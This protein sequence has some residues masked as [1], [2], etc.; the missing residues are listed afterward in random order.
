M[1][2][3]FVQYAEKYFKILHLLRV[4]GYANVESLYRKGF[5]RVLVFDQQKVKLLQSKLNQR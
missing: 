5:M 2:N 1:T 3:V 4:G